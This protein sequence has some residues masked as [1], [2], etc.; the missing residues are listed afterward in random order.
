[1]YADLG[2][3]DNTN[4]IYSNYI[5]EVMVLEAQLKAKQNKP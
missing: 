3:D 4:K 2:L 1:M 5:F